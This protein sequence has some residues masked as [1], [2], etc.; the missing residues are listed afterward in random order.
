MAA[1][2]KCPG[3]DFTEKFWYNFHRNPTEWSLK[4]IIQRGN[5]GKNL[6]GEC[7]CNAAPEGACTQVRTPRHLLYQGGQIDSVHRQER[8]Y[9]ETNS[10]PLC[11]D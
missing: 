6:C 8:K 10:L 7:V 5:H 9:A 11:R 1:A 3:F 4:N 2:M